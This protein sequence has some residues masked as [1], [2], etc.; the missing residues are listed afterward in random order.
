MF[1]ISGLNSI[2][3][4]G[5]DLFSDQYQYEQTDDL[6]NSAAALVRSAALHDIALPDTLQAIARAGA[7]V[8]NIPLDTCAEQGVVVFNTPGANANGVKEAVIAGLLL[9]SRDI[10]EGI[11]WVST[12]KDEPTV[13][14]LIEKKKA[15]FAGIEIKGKKIG[16]IGLGAVGVLVA[17]A[18][19]NLEMEVY[20]YD[21]FI[22]VD[23]AWRLSKHVR[24]CRSI[25]EIYRD[26]DFITVHVPLS[27]DTKGM[28]NQAT[29]NK[30]K[31]DVILLNFSRDA[32][33][34][35]DDVIAALASGKVKRYVTDFPNAQ[36]AGAQGVIAI[37]HLG[38]S[39]AESED[40]C[41]IMAVEQIVD[42]LEN[43]NIKNSVNYPDCNLGR[44]D[45]AGRIAINY[46][47][48]PNMLSQFTTIFSKNNINISNMLNKS[49]DIWAYTLIDIDSPLTDDIIQALRGIPD[50]VKVRAIK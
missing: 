18:A 43:G 17:N 1:K 4:I 45:T 37:P 36:T 48:I 22:S 30:M 27:K 16:V 13:D 11:N 25:E 38:A 10:V 32:L 39:T 28:F 40:T 41:A 47:N 26:C 46:R 24:H 15:N 29:F 8:N 12:V 9:S 19:K 44:C 49:R 20:G 50:V 42:F 2:A 14:K 23:A 35:D 5:L 33:F 6:S 34:N 3:Q 21:P 31:D 7:G